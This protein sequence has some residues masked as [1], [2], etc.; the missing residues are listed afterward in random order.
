MKVGNGTTLAT[1]LIVPIALFSL[2]TNAPAQTPRAVVTW[3]PEALDFTLSV[4]ESATSTVSIS[5]RRTYRNLSVVVPPEL[6]D[7]VTI[8]P[9][10]FDLNRRS[11][12]DIQLDVS[13]PAG[14]NSTITGDLS[15]VRNFW[16]RQWPV[17]RADALQL[18]VSL[19]PVDVQV[20]VHE[21]SGASFHVP[22]DSVVVL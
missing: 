3:E 13:I 6:Q 12:T 7:F 17:R 16:G 2:P 5:S 19:Q 4:G 15:L 20:V 9:G 22:I 21:E 8:T 11:T 10:T 14:V 1:L 18:T